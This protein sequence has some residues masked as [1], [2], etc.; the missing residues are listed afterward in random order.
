MGYWI[1]GLW[2]WCLTKTLKTF[3]SGLPSHQIMLLNSP[4]FFEQPGGSLFLTTINKTA[5]AWLGAIA[6]AEHALRLLPPGTHDWNKFIP[7]QELLFLLEKS[8]YFISV[9]R[10]C[11]IYF[12]I[13]SLG[14][15]R[16]LAS[17]F[18]LT[19]LL[20]SDGLV[21]RTVHGMGYN[22]LLN[23]WFWLSNTSINYA[24]HA[25]KEGN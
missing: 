1:A 21:T 17:N 2:W 15:H 9:H 22:P 14:W 3:F 10:N 12:I 7:R 20:F 6:I 8:K 18:M 4:N 23:E 16:K 19:K 13:Q 24:V 25:I 5:C 11:I